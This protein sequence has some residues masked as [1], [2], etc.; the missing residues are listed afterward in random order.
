M[1]RFVAKWAWAGA[2]LFGLVL[3]GSGAFMVQQGRAAHN[4]VK[5]TLAS[6]NVV[7]SQDADIPLKPVTNA[8]TAK[9]QADAIKAHVLRT[10]GG[11]GYAELPSTDPN[12]TTALNSITLRTAL[13]ESYMAFKI[14]DLVMGVG[15]IVALVGASHVVLGAYLAYITAQER[16]DFEKAAR[17]GIG[18]PVPAT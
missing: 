4:D 17:A 12:R 9:A 18:Q 16:K 1:K 11:R 2:I 13:M 10:T 8:A 6:E 5:D 14:A 15:L 7:S 3:A